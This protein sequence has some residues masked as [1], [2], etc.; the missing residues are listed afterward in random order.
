MYYHDSRLQFPVNVSE[1]DPA[2]ARSH[3]QAIGGVEGE[4]RVCMRSASGADAR[5][6]R[7][8]LSGTATRGTATTD[9]EADRLAKRQVMA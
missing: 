5:G 1:P 7:F 9:E 2:C 3:Q 6:T 4:I 8:L